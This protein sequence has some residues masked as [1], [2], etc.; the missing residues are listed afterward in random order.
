MDGCW[1]HPPVCLV[2]DK[3]IVSPRI[4]PPQGVL[5]VATV[6]SYTCPA[7]TPARHSFRTHNAHRRSVPTPV[8]FYENDAAET[9][10]ASFSN[11]I[12]FSFFFCLLW[13]FHV[14]FFNCLALFS[15]PHPFDYFFASHCSDL[16]TAFP[17][18]FYPFLTC[19]FSSSSPCILS[20]SIHVHLHPHA[21][22]YT[23]PSTCLLSHNRSTHHPPSHVRLLLIHPG[24]GRFTAWNKSFALSVHF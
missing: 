12:N 23:F 6:V 16:S 4:E 5:R 19:F 8:D 22:W 3:L 18:S 21:L 7:R 15:A 2:K 1:Q 13:F 24:R 20:F 10:S 9:M 11:N 14:F 17:L